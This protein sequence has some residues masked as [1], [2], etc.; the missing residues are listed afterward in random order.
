MPAKD[1][2]NLHEEFHST[3]DE[4]TSDVF[5]ASQL[6][7]LRLIKLLAADLDPRRAHFKTTLDGIE[8]HIQSLKKSLR[9]DEPLQQSQIHTA[10][11]K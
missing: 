6:N 1:S 5:S 11:E 9:L 7:T 2:R 8:A 3:K 4:I 10:K